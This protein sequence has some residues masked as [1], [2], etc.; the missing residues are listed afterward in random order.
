MHQLQK[1][2]FELLYYRKR[3]DQSKDPLSATK[4]PTVFEI[5]LQKWLQFVLILI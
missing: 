5:H 2:I 1:Y 4:I 3:F